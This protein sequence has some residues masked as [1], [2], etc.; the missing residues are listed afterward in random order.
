MNRHD[1]PTRLFDIVA[2]RA[3]RGSR[4]PC[5]RYGD[6]RLTAEE[7]LR[8]AERLSL[9]LV[10]HGLRRGEAVALISDNRPEWNIID[11]GV[12]QAG[13]VLLPLCKGLSA[14][15]YV[16]C[17]TQAGVRTLFVEDCELLSRFRLLLPQV[18]S[19]EQVVLLSG[20]A[21]VLTL[22]A[23]LAEEVC[24]EEEPTVERRRNM[25]TTDDVC[26]LVYTGGG[27]YSRLTHRQ[28]LCDI[29]AM[30]EVEVAGRH[31]ASGNKA[32]CT[33]YG[34]LQN[35]ACQMV[36]RTVEYPVREAVA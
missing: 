4:R 11:I 24:A 35:Y 8:Q 19:V 34:R 7:Y 16:E 18:E 20:D 36:G 12:M 28:L 27:T 25:V 10:G 31:A 23:L 13:G 5:F 30:A 17:L 6:V 32:L 29:E 22:N 33:R 2:E 21:E 9:W 15:E 1:N 3:S 26:T 14:E